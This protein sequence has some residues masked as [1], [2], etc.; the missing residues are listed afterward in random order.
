MILT[1][2]K[3]TNLYFFW[4]YKAQMIHKN[5]DKKTEEV[6]SIWKAGG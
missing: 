2:S 3:L 4:E 6:F 5:W 1:A